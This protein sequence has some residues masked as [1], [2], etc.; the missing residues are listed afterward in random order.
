M[1]PINSA[2][3]SYVY[4]VSGN[5]PRIV[6]GKYL[7]DNKGFDIRKTDE[8]EPYLAYDLKNLI[9]KPLSKLNLTVIPGNAW[10]TKKPYIRHQ[11]EITNQ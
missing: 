4:E 5:G 6:T 1:I 2:D 11:S 7:K 9:M 10:M 8:T 3:D